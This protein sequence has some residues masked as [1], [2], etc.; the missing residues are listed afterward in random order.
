[1]FIGSWIGWWLGDLI[2]GFGWAF[3]ISGLGSIAGVIVGW[4]ISEEYF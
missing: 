3:F 4:K 2:G 1:M